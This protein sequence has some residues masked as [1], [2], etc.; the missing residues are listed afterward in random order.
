M[1]FLDRNGW[2]F[3]VGVG[4]YMY[5]MLSSGKY[6]KFRN[7]KAHIKKMAEYEIFLEKLEEIKK[8]A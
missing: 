6:H 5:Y 3:Y 2:F 4:T 1:V 7:E 8:V